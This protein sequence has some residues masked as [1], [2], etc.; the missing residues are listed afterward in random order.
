M[1]SYKNNNLSFSDNR[2][3]L[4]AGQKGRCY[5]TGKLLNTENMM[6]HRKI[7]KVLNGNNEYKNL[8]WITKEI[9][10]LIHKSE[11]YKSEDIEFIGSLNE[12]GLKRLNSL[13]KLVGNSVIN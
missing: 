4:M 6:C 10:E 3:S 9:H 12:I 2:I 7:P 13:R 11:C 1:D 5:V 8:V